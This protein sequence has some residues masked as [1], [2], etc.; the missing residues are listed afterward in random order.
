MNYPLLFQDD[1]FQTLSRLFESGRFPHALIFEG[2]VGSGKRTAADFAAK[3][4]LCRNE[5]APCGEC[6]SCKKLLSNNHPDFKAITPENKSKTINVE[7]VREIK[8]SAYIAPHESKC[9]VYL[10]PNAHQLR[11]EAQNA[12]LKLIE[13]PPASAYFILTVPSRANLLETVI[14]RC[15]VLS[16]REL[17]DDER[18]EAVAS[19]RGQL[20][21]A[22][23]ETVLGCKTAGEALAALGDPKARMLEQDAREICGFVI[24]GGRYA[25][26][27]LLNGYEKDRE[28]YR[29]LLSAMR[30]DIIS[31]LCSQNGKL[32]ALRAGKIIDIID[33]ADF[34]AGQN[35][36]LGLLSCALVNRL[37]KAASAI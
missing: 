11:V 16:M 30:A 2:P 28:D 19:V 33:K 17:S 14:S 10:I 31:R 23:R 15:T 5:N 26:L 12:L 37:I 1:I 34:S 7:Q 20:T 22:E 13:E 18:L 9:K 4:L 21:T 6:V 25:A 29:R 3:M 36:A 8:L 24:S 32:S 35:A 27:K